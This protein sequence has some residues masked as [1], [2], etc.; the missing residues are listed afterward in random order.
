MVISGCFAHLLLPEL[1]LLELDRQLLRDEL[2]FFII[3]KEPFSILF[4]GN[5]V[6]WAAFGDKMIIRGG[7]QKCQHLFGCGIDQLV[8]V[9]NDLSI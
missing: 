7:L 5:A 8:S 3:F 4:K 2:A 9:G 6:G 1:V